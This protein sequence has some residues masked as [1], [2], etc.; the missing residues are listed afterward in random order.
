MSDLKEELIKIG[1]DSPDLRPHIRNILDKTSSDDYDIGD[2]AGRII[3]LL[4]RELGSDTYLN[5]RGDENMTSHLE[6]EVIEIHPTGGILPSFILHVGKKR[7]AGGSLPFEVSSWIPEGSYDNPSETFLAQ[8]AGGL[9][10][11]NESERREFARNVIQDLFE[12]SQE[13]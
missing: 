5:W 4:E 6:E 9:H 8:S 2:E 12:F 3:N 7:D 13:K 10:I 1:N 11:K